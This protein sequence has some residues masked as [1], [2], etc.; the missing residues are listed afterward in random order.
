MNEHVGNDR[1]GVVTA[2][3]TIRIERILPGPVERVWAYLTE[4]DKRK[5][6]LAE[7]PMANY[8]GGDVELTFYHS[9]LSNEPTPAD[10][11]KYEGHT[12][13]GKVTRYEPPSFLSFT[14]PESTGEPSEVTFELTASGSDTLLRVTHTRL[15]SNDSMVSVASGWHT[16]LGVL[17]DHLSGEQT[18]GFWDKFTRLEKEY[19]HIIAG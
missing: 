10:Y 3:R 14:W 7:G 9:Q 19:K 11:Q 16:H 17:I 12:N 13:K 18:S 15:G 8:V 4:S 2:P 1:L 6:W 5:K